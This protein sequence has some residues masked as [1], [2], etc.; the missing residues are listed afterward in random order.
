MI[1]KNEFKLFEDCMKKLEEIL[2]EKKPS[3]IRSWASIDSKMQL[4][5]D[6]IRS[7]KSSSFNRSFDDSQPIQAKSV[8]IKKSS[9][10]LVFDDKSR[11][12]MKNFDSHQSF[13][14]IS[15][16]TDLISQNFSFNENKFKLSRNKVKLVQINENNLTATSQLAHKLFNTTLGNNNNFLLPNLKKVK[17]EKDLR[18][19]LSRM[20]SVFVHH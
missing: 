14:E 16:Q 3:K 13:Q 18:N 9:S 11:K 20:H 12:K 1:I 17:N 15:N 10:S 5:Q 7:S 6:L 2:N 8:L 4:H 19:G